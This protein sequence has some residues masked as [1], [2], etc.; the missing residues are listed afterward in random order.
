MFSIKKSALFHLLYPHHCAGCGS[1][2]LSTD[3]FL[4][5]N[6]IQDL[7][8]TH[9]AWHAGNPVE[10]VFW[11][12]LP[13]SN[14]MSTFYFSKSSIVQNL[15]HELKYKGNKSIGKY[16]GNLIGQSLEQS[17]RF[18][19]I[20]ALIPLPLFEKKEKQRG[21]NQAKILCEGIKEVLNA[22]IIEK[23]VIRKIPT[24]TQTRKGRIQRWENVADTFL[25]LNPEELNGRH[26][27]LVDDV[28]TTGATLEACGA[29]ILK[30]G[31]TQLS[32][33]TLAMA[34]H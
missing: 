25:I 13:I 1:D 11:G 17:N 22:S 33:A 28:I 26:V 3:Q 34:T 2:I 10:K 19:N 20:D 7:P 31:N 29:A 16:M 4:C 23:N 18:R 12:R 21:Y 6:C 5:I 15:I 24:E 14:A 32:I 9:F 27:L 30:S 8:H